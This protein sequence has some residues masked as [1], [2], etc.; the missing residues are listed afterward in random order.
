MAPPTDTVVGFMPT[1]Q[2]DELYKGPKRT[3]L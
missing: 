3:D 2:L 1:Q